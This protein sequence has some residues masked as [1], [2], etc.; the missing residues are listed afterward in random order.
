MTAETLPGYRGKLREL[1][2]EA[3]VGVG[4]VVRVHT[5]GEA[6]EQ[7]IGTL[8]LNRRPDTT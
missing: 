8:S 6:F 5:G 1:L 2:T 4:D 3:K 7:T